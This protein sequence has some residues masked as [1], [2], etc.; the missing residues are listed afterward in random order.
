MHE[1]KSSLIPK[2][3]IVFLGFSI[4]SETMKIIPTEG[5]ITKITQ[6]GQALLQNLNPTIREVAGFVGLVG[7]Y[8]VASEYGANHSKDLELDKNEA[9]RK[10][11]GNYDR[12]MSI[13]DSGKQDI[14]WWLNNIQGLERDFSVIQ[15]HL[16]ITTDASMKGWGAVCNKGSTNGR[17][18]ELEKQLHINV[19]EMMAILFGL[20]S[21]V[22]KGN[23]NIRLLSDNSTR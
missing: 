12:C 21:F 5:K 14:W 3:Q 15:W 6:A 18:N 19:L 2:K 7:A 17:W 8:S 13:S 10:H 22:K 9:L 23:L 4:N 1:Q 20:K 11:R 16:T